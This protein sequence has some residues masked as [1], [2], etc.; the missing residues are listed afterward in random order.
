[1]S[2]NPFSL[3]GSSLR[4]TVKSAPGDPV[5][6]GPTPTTSGA[7]S[8]DG[9][10]GL[11]LDG[12]GDDHRRRGTR[13]G[14]ER[15]LEQ[16]LPLDGFDLAP[17]R[18]RGRQV[19]VER[20][21]PEGDCDQ[22]ERRD[23]P[24]RPMPPFDPDSEPTPGATS[25]RRPVLLRVRVIDARHEGPE[26][27]AP[28][29]EQQRGKDGEHRRR[30]DCDAHR[31]DRAEP[32]RR[33]DGCERKAQQRRDDRACRRQDP[34]ACLPNRDQ[35]GLVLVLVPVE[36]LPVA[37]CEKQ[38]VVGPRSEDEH[39]QDPSRL[40]VHDEACLYEQRPES[41][42]ERLGEEDGQQR[43]HPEDGASVDDDEEDE[44]EGRGGEE[45]RGVDA[46]ERLA[47]VGG[48][49]GRA[50]DLRLESVGACRN[51][52]CI[53]STASMSTFSSP[54]ATIW[55]TTSAASPSSEYRGGL[56]ATAPSGG[57]AASSDWTSAIAARS[58]GVSPPGRENTAIAATPS[59]DGNSSDS[60]SARTDSAAAGRKLEGSFFCLDSNWPM[61]RS[62]SGERG[63]PDPENDELRAAACDESGKRGHG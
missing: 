24:D 27:A 51:R 21:R 48:V 20:Q 46:L 22:R 38:R 4:V 14:R 61:K 34:G 40:P 13:A 3:N 12:I 49:P 28:A 32:G 58:A 36:L 26:R 62:E 60:A 8:R 45:E 2:A 35:H 16:P 57:D 31:A 23:G 17:E 55:T 6:T 63:Q 1:M 50:G 54:F 33:I 47:C 9:E 25:P 41:A 59:A 39:E 56:V 42:H 10:H 30:G 53:D 37:R 15:A 44:D 11:E 7:L 29:D 52:L 43:E 5:C 19:R 18:V